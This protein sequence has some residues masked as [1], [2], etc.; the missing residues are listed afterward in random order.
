MWWAYT[1]FGEV[2]VGNGTSATRFIQPDGSSGFVLAAVLSLQGFAST[3][4]NRLSR[5]ADDESISFF[6]LCPQHPVVWAELPR[7]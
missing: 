1:S 2:D 6:P 4:G 7:M 5:A 3:D